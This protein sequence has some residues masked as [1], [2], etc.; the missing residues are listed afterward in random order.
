MVHL[1]DGIRACSASWALDIGGPCSA[2]RRDFPLRE[3]SPAASTAAGRDRAAGDDAGRLPR[4]PI[5][6]TYLSALQLKR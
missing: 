1:R 3:F 4:R 2:A 6:L 5:V